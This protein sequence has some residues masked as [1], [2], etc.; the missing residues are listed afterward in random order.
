MWTLGN[1]TL[2]GAK[3]SFILPPTSGTFTL[4]LVCIYEII[5]HHFTECIVCTAM[6]MRMSNLKQLRH[7]R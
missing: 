4:L 1:N 6:A 3:W 5:W 2:N 7:H